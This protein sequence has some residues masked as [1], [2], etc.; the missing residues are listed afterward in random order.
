[1]KQLFYRTVMASL[2]LAAV[3]LGA[4]GLV[5]VICTLLLSLL[6]R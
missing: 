1:M 2:I 6:L 4:I 5:Y 3:Y